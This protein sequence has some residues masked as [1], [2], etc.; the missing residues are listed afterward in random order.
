MQFTYV[1][2]MLT[3]RCNK[4]CE[5]CYQGRRGVDDSNSEIVHKAMEFIMKNSFSENV[6]V[7]LWGGEPLLRFD[8]M[9]EL[10]STYPHIRFG[11]ATNGALLTPEIVDFL[12]K[13]KDTV[14]IGLSIET[15][16]ECPELYDFH[17]KCSYF[18]HLIVTDVTKIYETVRKLYR[19]GIRNFQIDMAHLRNY[20]DND[21]NIYRKE[22]QSVVDWGRRNF[23]NKA[24][25]DVVTFEDAIRLHFEQ[26]RVGT[27]YCGAGYSKI[28][29]SP[30]GEIYPCD[31]F[32]FIGKYKMGDIFNG[33]S[34][35]DDVFK[36]V[37]HDKKNTI[38]TCKEC[39]LADTCRN[40]VCLAENYVQNQTILKPVEAT[41]RIKKLEKNIIVNSMKRKQTNN[42]QNFV[43]SEEST[44]VMGREKFDD[45]RELFFTNPGKNALVDKFVDIFN[46]VRVYDICCKSFVDVRANT[47]EYYAADFWSYDN[48][49]VE[50]ATQVL[51][52][53]GMNTDLNEFRGIMNIVDKFNDK[54]VHTKFPLAYATSFNFNKDAKKVKFY[55]RTSNKSEL[56]NVVFGKLSG[57]S[58]DDV[59]R[60]T[61]WNANSRTLV[62]FV[63]EEGKKSQQRSYISFDRKEYNAKLFDRLDYIKKLKDC[64]A[65]VDV[66]YDGVSARECYLSMP[67]IE[68]FK[69][70]IDNPTI[71]NHLDFMAECDFTADAIGVD[72][73]DVALYWS[74]ILTSLGYGTQNI[75]YKKRKYC[76]V[77]LLGVG[78]SIKKKEVA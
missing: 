61:G 68:K 12:G 50:A 36:K 27:N 52:E 77:H 45:Y 48:K 39:E 8:L 22:M 13:N 41:C 69:K 40:C 70:L 10:I 30:K 58:V 14:D 34:A 49:S 66:D 19:K 35:E 18:V 46:R 75:F 1:W 15:G 23:Y 16:A 29:I 31:W 59:V 5:F 56:M 76:P 63:F 65:A 47:I 72:G 55:I 7:T 60:E 33:V 74:P 21:I 37:C 53:F 64:A 38:P 32:Y 57:K 9:K 24:Q 4:D 54:N 20:S 44:G 43:R 26:E 62:A 11:F 67:D 2:L 73:K 17:K 25:P 78:F 71:L 51:K 3:D 42:T 28:A 6:I